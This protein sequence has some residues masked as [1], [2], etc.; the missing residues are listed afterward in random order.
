MKKICVFFKKLKIDL[1]F[2]PTIPSLDKYPKKQYGNQTSVPYIHYRI[3]ARSSFCL[4]LISLSIKSSR[5]IQMIANSKI[6]LKLISVPCVCAH[7][8]CFIF[9]TSRFIKNLWHDTKYVRKYPFAAF[10]PR[11]TLIQKQFSYH[12]YKEPLDSLLGIFF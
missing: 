6:S 9:S 1:S 4:Q 3:S 10:N 11:V 12:Y 2:D 5:V 8:L 7:V